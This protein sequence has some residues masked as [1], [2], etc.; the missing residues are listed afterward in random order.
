MD[1]F[2]SFYR[3]IFFSISNIN[4][5]EAAKDSTYNAARRNYEADSN[6]PAKR[7]SAGGD[8]ALLAPGPQSRLW[9]PPGS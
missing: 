2:F 1:S 6:V 3:S 7:A 9:D 8:S 5:M 4:V